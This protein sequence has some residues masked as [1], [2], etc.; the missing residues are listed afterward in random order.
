M[1]QKKILLLVC[2][3]FVCIT[4]QAQEAV[5]PA[6]I[7]TQHTVPS[8]LLDTAQ[9]IQVYLPPSYT[10]TE[11][12][13]P[14]LYIL[15]G[16]L[17]YTLGVSI[18]TTLRQ[19]NKTP[20]FIIVGITT[21]FPQRYRYFG[22]DKAVFMD[23]IE[24]E[25]VPYV[26]ATYRTKKENMLFG[27]QYA[28][29]LAFDF[30]LENKPLFNGYFMASP[31]PIL[32]NVAAVDSIPVI[33]KKL[34]FS[35]S[36]DE[37]DVNF[38]VDTLAAVLSKKQ[39]KA[40]DWKSL[41]LQNEEHH[42]TPYPTLYHSLRNYFTYYPEF[43][44][45]NLQKLRDAGGLE[46]AYR[47]A[48][49]RGDTYGLSDTLSTWS[50][51]TIIRSAIRANDYPQFEKFTDALLTD[52]FLKDLKN[53]AYEIGQFYDKHTKYTEA[54]AIYKVLL[55]QRPDS[56]RLLNRIAN[57]YQAMGQTKEAQQ[58]RQQIKNKE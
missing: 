7:G 33:D 54:I 24:Q 20:E 29:S 27:W 11:T 3:I 50:K 4:I 42:S 10:T 51:F 18:Q 41:Y 2:S 47:Y 26:D 52:D 14:V 43:Q 48:Q 57:A 1:S 39:D 44:E 32:D 46:Y 45:D 15:D 53:R 28:G 5:T 23:Y 56:E 55:E 13:Y 8:T 21:P 38:G 22:N 40:L 34:Y 12:S 6:T 30:M 31:F 49:Q 35:V 16:Q 36:P 17:F 9:E 25:L 19:F 37:Y 58:Y